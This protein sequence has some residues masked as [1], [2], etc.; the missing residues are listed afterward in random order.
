MNEELCI[1]SFASGYHNLFR[2][3]LLIL[4]QCAGATIAGRSST[5]SPL[6]AGGAG[7][8]SVLTT[9]CRKTITAMGNVIHQKRNRNIAIAETVAK[10]CTDYLSAAISAE[11]YSAMTVGCRKIMDVM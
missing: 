11:E 10:N 5:N 9:T 1:I 4:T 2:P 3:P 7:T 8:S 6:R